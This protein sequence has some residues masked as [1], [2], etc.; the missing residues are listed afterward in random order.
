MES[1]S[2]RSPLV[3][4]MVRS[5]RRRRISFWLA[6]RTIVLSILPVWVSLLANIL[7]TTV[8]IYFLS[9]TSPDPALI[10]GIGLA[11]TLNN[12]ILRTFIVGYNV[13]MITLSSQAAGSGEVDKAA[14]VLNRT[15][16]SGT[17][18]FVLMAGIMFFIQELIYWIGIEPAVADVAVLYSRIT[19]AAFL[20]WMYYDSFR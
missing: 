17:L 12:C 8:T 15:L 13:G 7:A 5:P 6:A 2:I 9:R 14:Q 11:I 18:F 16:V 1:P 10:A 19:L 20:I 3:E 4:G